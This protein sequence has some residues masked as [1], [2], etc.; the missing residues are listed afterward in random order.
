MNQLK[1]ELSSVREKSAF[2]EETLLT[3]QREMDRLSQE[4][5]QA[6][7]EVRT[8][9]HMH[10]PLTTYI[11][12]YVRTYPHGHPISALAVITPQWSQQ[13]PD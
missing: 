12:M 5:D 7:N 6:L 1:E 2:S 10:K 13:W 11:R 9:V 4:L 3:Q 8:Y